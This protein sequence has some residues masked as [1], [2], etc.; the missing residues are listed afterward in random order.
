M[1]CQASHPEE[2]T[3]ICSLL[4]EGGQRVAGP[5]SGV[6][7]PHVLYRGRLPDSQEISAKQ[8]SLQWKAPWARVWI[9]ENMD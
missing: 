2:E 9:Q 8:R 7:C 6:G 5:A 4:L 3:L 1:V